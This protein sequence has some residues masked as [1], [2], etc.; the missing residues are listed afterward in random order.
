MN[1]T[2]DNVLAQVNVLVDEYRVQCLWF[3]REDYHPA[4]LAEAWQALQYIE[5]HGDL[6]AL[7][8]VAPLKQWLSRN[9]NAA[10]V[11]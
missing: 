1:V 8:R 2:A 7:Q 5:R 11:A 4:S 6:L 10:S 9:S 3:W